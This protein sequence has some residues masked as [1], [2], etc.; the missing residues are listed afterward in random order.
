VTRTYVHVLI[1]EAVVIVA[2]IWL[3]YAFS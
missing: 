3:G 2:L 1:I